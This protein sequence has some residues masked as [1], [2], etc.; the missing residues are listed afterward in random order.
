MRQERDG[1]LT[2][3]IPPQPEGSIVRY[4]LITKERRGLPTLVH[5]PGAPEA[6]T[7]HY[8]VGTDLEPPR[9][10][11]TARGAAAAFGWPATLF[12][13]IDDNLGIA[14]AWVE[15]THNG[16]PGARLGLGRDAGVSRRWTTAFPNV[17]VLGDEFEYWILAVDASRAGNTT[18]LP[19]TGGYRFQLVETLEDGF[20]DGGSWAHRSVVLAQ[21]DPW[22]L[23]GLD[24]R[25]PGGARAWRCGS[26]SGE[27]DP[28]VAAELVTD[29]FGLGTGA[30]ARVWSKMDAEINLLDRC[31]DGGVVQI[32]E[33]GDLGWTPLVPIG[34]YTHFMS[35]TGGT[36]ILPPGTPCL[37]GRD[38]DWRRFDFDL[39]AWDGRRVRIRFLFGTDNVLSPSRDLRGWALDDF[40]LDPGPRRPTDAGAGPPAPARLLAAAPSPNPFNPSL[41]F[42]LE[43]PAD[44]GWVRLEIFDPA[45]RRVRSLFAGALPP[46]PRRLTWDGDRDSGVATPSGV[47]YYRLRSRLGDERGR[48][49]LLR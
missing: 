43:A 32:Q 34:G 16:V 27:Y 6:G 7:H 31:F 18:R 46:G 42:D 49:V 37:S 8:R 19:A 24:N 20:E 23:S 26:A 38:A 28:N 22:H 45:G 40:Q 13:T 5:P 39:S 29:V 14:A 17:G 21:P 11:H 9:I 33:E 1:S 15:Y 44:L 47:Y 35:D 30:Q 12:A 36:N 3:E 48:V 2:G 4:Y 25:T 41:H 10:E